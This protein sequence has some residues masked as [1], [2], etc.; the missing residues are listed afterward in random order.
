MGSGCS[1]FMQSLQ[2]PEKRLPKVV[3]RPESRNFNNQSIH[4]ISKPPAPH[5]LS[6]SRVLG[7][8]AKQPPVGI[9][10]SSKSSVD[11]LRANSFWSHEDDDRIND[12]INHW[13]A[14]EVLYLKVLI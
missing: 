4:G 7:V 3:T 14:V 6:I 13:K 9:D 1:S 8:T 11:I 2:P 5:P 10:I 12:V